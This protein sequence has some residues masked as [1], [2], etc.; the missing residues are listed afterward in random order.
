MTTPNQREE[1]EYIWKTF[2]DAVE[3]EIES[4][5]F[6]ID[7]AEWNSL[8]KALDNGEVAATG[9]IMALL[10]Q[11]RN[12]VL[13]EVILN[14]PKKANCKKR[15]AEHAGMDIMIDI[16]HAAIEAVRREENVK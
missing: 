14:L 2:N 16:V 13:D 12:R 15:C 11:E 7:Q 6:A 1:I 4:Q 5:E 8:L 9:A 10:T 3:V